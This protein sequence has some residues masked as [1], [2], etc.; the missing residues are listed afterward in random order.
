VYYLKTAKEENIEKG[1]VK[2]LFSL[3]IPYISSSSHLSQIS[4]LFLKLFDVCAGL[5]YIIL[6]VI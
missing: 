5:R 6:K 4:F 3:Y 2:S 1:G